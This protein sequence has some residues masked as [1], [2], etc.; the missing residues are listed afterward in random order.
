MVFIEE[1]D[2]IKQKRNSG[3][4]GGNDEREQTLHQ[5]LKKMDALRAIPY[6]HDYLGGDQPSEPVIIRKIR[7]Y[8]KNSLLLGYRITI[9]FSLILIVTNLFMMLNIKNSYNKLLDEDTQANQYILY[10]RVNSLLTGRNIRDAYLVP[11]SEAN[12]AM[13]RSAEKAQDSLFANIELLKE[14]FPSQLERSKLDEYIAQ[15]IRWADTNPQLIEWYRQYDRTGKVF[16]LSMKRIYRIRR[17]WPQLQQPWTIIWFR[18]WLT[19]E[20][21]LN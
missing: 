6:R 4:I 21:V 8:M 3:M 18:A 2:A 19:S 20:S 16:S 10:C 13:L 17:R 15:T 5:L 9:G 11:G 14:H 12:E 1:F 7:E